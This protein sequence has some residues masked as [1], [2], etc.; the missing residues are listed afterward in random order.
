MGII[1]N[2]FTIVIA[3]A[4]EAS[5]LCDILGSGPLDYG[6]YFFWIGFNTIFRNYMAQI[7]QPIFKEF[8]FAWFK[9][10]TRFVQFFK[11]LPKSFY[12]FLQCFRENDNII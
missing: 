1:L 5:D 8:T 6:H 3:E 11:D 7:F 12:V 2:E 9:P 4:Q 10:E